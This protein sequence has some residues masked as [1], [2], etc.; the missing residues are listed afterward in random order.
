MKAGTGLGASEKKGTAQ[1]PRLRTLTV[2][3]PNALLTFTPLPTAK[4]ISQELR[5]PGPR[6]PPKKPNPRGVVCP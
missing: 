3:S 2:E 4:P 6:L 1:S 5:A